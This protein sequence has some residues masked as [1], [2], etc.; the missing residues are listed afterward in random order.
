MEPTVLVD[1]TPE[2][3]VMREEVFGPLLPVLTWREPHEVPGMVAAVKDQPL[4]MYMFSS[5]KRNLCLWLGATRSGTVAIGETVIQIA[6]P[7]LPFGGVQASGAG[8]SN[9]RASFDEFSNRRSVMRKVFPWTAAPLSY[10]PFG[11]VKTALAKWM[12][13]YL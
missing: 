4:S 3:R 7:D 9:G 2:M 8:R 5:R 11:P 1:V 10:P 6:N 13:R 12:S